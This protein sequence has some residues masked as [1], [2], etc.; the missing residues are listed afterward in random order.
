MEAR[1]LERARKVELLVLDVDGVLTDGGLYYGPDGEALKR[2]DVRDGHGIVLC[3]DA[4]LPT[5]I[6]SA[7]VSPAVEAR[8]RE[9]RIPFVLQGERDKG[10]GLDRL[11]RRCGLPAEALAYIGDDLN[12]LP[13]LARVGFSAAPA[14]A[15]PEVRERVHYV[16]ESRG[17]HGA[18][19]ELCELILR[20]KGLW[21][22]AAAFHPPSP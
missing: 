21:E 18:V 3:R 13:V 11:L 20:A 14:D 7:R 5:A 9:L 17:G 1:W 2:F 8:A 6:L 15:R 4:G 22:R 12:D 16:C 19:R 10:T